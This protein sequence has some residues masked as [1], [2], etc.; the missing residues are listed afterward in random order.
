M[1]CAACQWFFFLLKKKRIK[2]LPRRTEKP[3]ETKPNARDETSWS[4]RRHS[5]SQ[6]APLPDGSVDNGAE[7]LPAQTEVLFL[8]TP[9]QQSDECATCR[10]V[11]PIWA[12]AALSRRAAVWQHLFNGYELPPPTPSRVSSVRTW[13]DFAVPEPSRQIGQCN[14]STIQMSS[15]R[16]LLCKPAEMFPEHF[17]FVSRIWRR[18]VQRKSLGK[19]EAI[20]LFPLPAQGC[21]SSRQ[22]V[23]SAT[24]L[25]ALWSRS[26]SFKASKSI[27]SIVKILTYFGL[28]LMWK[29]HQIWQNPPM[30]LLPR[31]TAVLF[32]SP[33]RNAAV[34]SYFATNKRRLNGSKI[35][36]STL[37]KVNM[38]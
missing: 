7:F 11:G 24:P 9:T 4:C 35:L 13:L 37:W 29:Q 34:L 16:F 19:G 17:Q 3:A 5:G 25:L 31:L 12:I 26:L 10:P 14:W 6:S 32:I 22:Q 33:L 15:S 28:F 23:G 2:R 20:D 18:R 30:K 36:D 1:Y 8:P 27:F 38:Q 21:R